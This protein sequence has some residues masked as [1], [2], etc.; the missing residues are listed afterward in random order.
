VSSSTSPVPTIIGPLSAGVLMTP[1]EFD[2]IADYD[3]RFN[4]ELIHGV[5]VVTPIPSEAESD[6]NE[7]LGFLLR[8]YQVHHPQGSTLD[9]TLAERYVYTPNM[10]R[11]ADRVIWAGLGRL[12]D[13]RR[14]VPTIVVEFVS[15]DK[16]D[17]QRDYEEKRLVYL[18]HGVEEYWVIDRFLRKLT[19]FRPGLGPEGAIDPLVFEEFQTYQSA[20][21]PGFELPLSRLL[22]IADRW[23]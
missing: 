20:I 11:R 19:V 15:A 22:A 7:E 18:E 2:E 23:K 10:R 17:R 16:R 21:L 12:P 13:T 4:Y 6:P 8:N 5:L 1:E 14:D 9:L 3:D